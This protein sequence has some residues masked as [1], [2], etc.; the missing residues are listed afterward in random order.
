MTFERRRST[1]VLT[2]RFLV[3]SWSTHAANAKAI[4]GVFIPR[5]WRGPPCVVESH[6]VADDAAGVLQGLEP[7][8]MYA[9]L[10]QGSDQSFH[11]AVL[12]WAV[13][14]D[15]LLSQASAVNQRDVAAGGEDQAVV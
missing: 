11:H 9:L 1:P 12:L 3:D 5:A 7:V 2:Q 10:F 6:P 13:R 15:E 14:R 4:A 8:S